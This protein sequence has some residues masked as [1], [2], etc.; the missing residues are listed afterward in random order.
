MRTLTRAGLTLLLLAALACSA[1]DPQP[2]EWAGRVE[3]ALEKRGLDDV[4][5]PFRL[6]DDMRQWLHEEVPR[7]AEDRLVTTLIDRLLSDNG[8][9]MEYS[10][11]ING[12]AVEV[13]RGRKANCLSF[14]FLFVGL[15]RELGVPTYFLQV[16]D[17]ERYEKEGD[18]VVLSDHVAVGYGPSH[19]VRII[20]FAAEEG[21]QYRRIQAISDYTAIALYYS[22]L[23]ADQLRRGN[24]GDAI[25]LLEKAVAIDPTLAAAWVNLGVSLRRNGEWG[26][27][28]EAYRQALTVDA[29]TVSAYLNL[30]A[31]L[32]IR[33]QEKEALE[34]LELVDR[35][36]NRNPFSYVALGD[37]SLRQGRLVDA[38][39]FYRR[40]LRV[41][42]D[43][44]EP[45]AALGLFALHVGDRRYAHRMLRRAQKL[46]AEADRVVELRSRLASPPRP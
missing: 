41:N 13:F 35:S 18:L 33:G 45:Y 22:N 9:A 40:A 10:R 31:L 30:A 28:E 42:A 39:R 16:R 37:L 1:T 11:D 27:A 36:G 14:T 23:G 25:A 44:A 6:D 7:T 29:D 3:D 2:A 4:V 38:E 12:T 19:D 24:Q 20:D 46:D 5:V 15:A 32:R 21:T 26:R 8:L 43:H 17:L 34:L